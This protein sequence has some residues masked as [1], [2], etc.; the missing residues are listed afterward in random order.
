V[1]VYNRTQFCPDAGVQTGVPSRTALSLLNHKVSH[2]WS[3]TEYD[4]SALLARGTVCPQDNRAAGHGAAIDWPV[5]VA[6]DEALV[7]PVA[8][9]E[10]LASPGVAS[11]GV[12]SACVPPPHATRTSEITPVSSAR[13]TRADEAATIVRSSSF[14]RPPQ[15]RMDRRAIVRTIR[16]AA[17]I[18]IEQSG[19]RH[20]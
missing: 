18:G 17:R 11:P 15:G 19:C 7:V 16:K 1:A 2:G 6:A 14:T 13:C 3:S 20:Q 5:G 8:S 9:A 10:T 4:P 12:A